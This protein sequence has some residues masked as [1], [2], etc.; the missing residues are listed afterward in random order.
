MKALKESSRDLLGAQRPGGPD[1]RPLHQAEIPEGLLRT[2]KG[3]SEKRRDFCRRYNKHII[4]AA[5][6]ETERMGR[7]EKPSNRQWVENVETENQ[8]WAL[9]LRKHHQNRTPTSTSIPTCATGKLQN[10][11]DKDQCSEAKWKRKSIKWQ[12][13]DVSSAARQG[14]RWWHNVRRAEGKLLLTCYPFFFF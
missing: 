6:R 1:L 14:S 8:T 3:D 9:R 5:K 11:Q 2:G 12:Q 10:T 7:R 13:L 4:G